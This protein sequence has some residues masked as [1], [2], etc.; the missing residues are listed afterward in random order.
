[1]IILSKALQYTIIFLLFFGCKESAT[2]YEP[3][4][5]PNDS[6]AQPDLNM[7]EVTF[8]LSKPDGSEKRTRIAEG[9]VSYNTTYATISMDP[10]AEFQTMEGFGFAV[11]G[12]S[13][14]HFQGMTQASRAALLN[15]LFGNGPEEIGLSFI[16]VSLGAS[17][18]DPEP[19]SYADTDNNVPDT[20][21]NT[22]TIDRDRQFLIP[23]L[24]EILSINPN[25]NIMASPWSPPKWMKNNKSTI[26]GRLLPEYYEAYAR[27]FVRYVE[28][29][30]AE[31]ITIHYLSVQNEPLHDGNNPSL[32]MTSGEQ[33]TF[34]KEHLGPIF[35]E[36]EID[37][38]ILLYDH[39][40][41]RVDYPQSILN[42]EVTR[43]F[44][45]GSAFHLYGGQISALSGLK[46]AHPDKHLFFTEQWYGAPGNFEGD[47]TW[48]IREIIIGSTRNWCEGV[49]EWNISSNP[50]LTPHTDG[51][52]TLCL[53]AVTIDGNRVI[54]NPG[55][56]VMA[57]VAPFVPPGSVRINSTYNVS[58]P[59]VAFLTPDDE[60][61]LIILNDSENFQRLSVEDGNSGF[62][63][64]LEAGN[65]AT[66]IW[67]NNVE[68]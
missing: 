53:G 46:S 6:T 13:A 20:A 61:V 50:S 32:Y 57:H 47:L 28:E 25:I 38:R 45:Y 36:K 44:V 63:L 68:N 21:L 19:F 23:T 26:G 35:K 14:R 49:I 17:D 37:T 9:I 34:I 2:Y 56:Y 5:S 39:N 67:K 8:Y 42:D 66:L 52:C 43:E 59:N 11:T 10:G 24:K 15:E 7:P 41:D 65:V 58:Y 33:N 4:V 51:G 60:I 48:H 3:P 31:G 55:Y 54:R 64:N 27:Y 62:S 40:A 1:M 29:M 12:G 22:F 16:R 30:A 18:L